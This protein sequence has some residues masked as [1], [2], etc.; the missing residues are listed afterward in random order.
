M[1]RILS[2]PPLWLEV[3]VVDRDKEAY[4]QN[5]IEKLHRKIAHLHSN[6]PRQRVAWYLPG[7]SGCDDF[8]SG[9]VYVSECKDDK[10]SPQVRSLHLLLHSALHVSV[11]SSEKNE[12]SGDQHDGYGRTNELLLTDDEHYYMKLRVSI[13]KYTKPILWKAQKIKFYI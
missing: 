5:V 9:Q 8:T 1:R 7:K 6:R 4:A 13:K 12:S 10:E 3:P 11:E 2:V